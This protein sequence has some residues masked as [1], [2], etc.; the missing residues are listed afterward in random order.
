MGALRSG[1][2]NITEKYPDAQILI[3]S[4]TYSWFLN[5]GNTC[6]TIQYG[7]NYLEEYVIGIELVAEEFGIDFIDIYHDFYPHEKYDDW[8][9]YTSDGLHPNEEGRKLITDAIVDYMKGIER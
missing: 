2:R 6:E 4:P 7:G 1:L 9:L 3:V 5:T 8:S